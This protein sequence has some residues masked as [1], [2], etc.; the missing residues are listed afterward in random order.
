MVSGMT[1]EE[2]LSDLLYCAYMGELPD[3][4]IKEACARFGIQYPPIQ[5]KGIQAT[6]Q[7]PV[8][9]SEVNHHGLSCN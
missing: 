1:N 5:F 2:F 6:Y 9:K 7:V 8:F 4:T 3:E